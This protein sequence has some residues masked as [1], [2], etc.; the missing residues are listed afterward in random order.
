[1]NAP[2]PSPARHLE[3]VDPATGHGCGTVVC[4]TD[5]EID[6][7]IR[8]A[9]HVQVDWAQR[10]IDERAA[11]VR[12]LGGL[13]EQHAQELAELDSR[14]SGRPVTELAEGD[15]PASVDALRW[16]AGAASAAVG[17]VFS[18][19]PSH[20]S[21]A[22]RRPLGVGAAVLPFNFPLAMAVWKTGPALLAGNALVLKPSVQTSGTAQ[23]LVELAEQA[24]A[25]AGLL[26]VVVGDG[27]VGSSLVGHPQIAAVSFTGSVAVGREVLAT[28]A[29][30]ALP[31]VSLEMGGKAAHLVLPDALSLGDRLLDGLV[32][33]GFLAAGQNC[34]AG[35]RILVHESIADELVERLVAR[36]RGLVVGDP[37][38][39]STQM[40]PLITEA[41]L[42]RVEA[43][44]SRALH[45]GAEARTG[46]ARVP[47]AGGW[48][49]APTV[50]TGV[51]ADH[52]I[53]QTEVFGPVVTVST[54]RDVDEAVARANDTPYGLAAAVWT[55]D[56]SSAH[57]VARRLRAGLVSVNA[58]SE[59][60]IRTPF[61]GLG[62][63]G[64]GAPEKSAAAFDQWQSRGSVWLDLAG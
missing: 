50:L 4:T 42:V 60:D 11:V 6:T 34:T 14:Q 31:R 8:R 20:L 15:L 37:A 17:T 54:V 55:R 12:R 5:A 7:V 2:A 29:H 38:D 41:S 22:V 51:P 28:C 19:G 47:G 10:P 23:R 32:E 33:A 13:I 43:L 53:E 30:G 45:D 9:A 1:V 26:A 64:F 27:D 48:Y 36:V 58:Y 61:G 18:D 63:S 62:L 25:P 40:G 16:F 21:Y 3:L 57:T 46:G 52:E 59:G 44:V 39:P 35:S 49:Y 56:L 24:G